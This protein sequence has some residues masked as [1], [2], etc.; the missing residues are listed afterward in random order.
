MAIIWLNSCLPMFGLF[1]GT[2]IWTWQFKQKRQRRR[3]CV[4]AHNVIN[5]LQMPSP[6]TYCRYVLYIYVNHFM[7]RCIIRLIQSLYVAI[8]LISNGV[9]SRHWLYLQYPMALRRDIDYIFNIQWRYVAIILIS[10]H[11]MSLTYESLYCYR[12][13]LHFISFLRLLNHTRC[14]Q[15]NKCWLTSVQT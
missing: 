6:I 10:N 15:S 14:T 12:F 5:K 8:T 4:V 7:S 9:M 13:H 3:T 2:S 11:V 1:L